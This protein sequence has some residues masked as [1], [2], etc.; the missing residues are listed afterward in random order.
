MSLFSY[1]LLLVLNRSFS[2]LNEKTICSRAQG[3]YSHYSCKLEE[4]PRVGRNNELC[5]FLENTLRLNLS[6]SKSESELLSTD[7][8]TSIAF[9]LETSNKDI[10]GNNYPTFFFRRGGNIPITRKDLY[11]ETSSFGIEYGSC[12]F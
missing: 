12:R 6:T 8:L 9:F 10:R 11:E 7:L 5:L 3:T 4:I 2:I 1:L